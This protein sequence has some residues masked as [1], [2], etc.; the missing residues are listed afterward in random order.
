MR[1]QQFESPIETAKRLGTYNQVD[2]SAQYQN[3]RYSS[4]ML[5][6]NQNLLFAEQRRQE[7]TKFWH[8][9]AILVISIALTNAPAIYLWL[10]KLA[11]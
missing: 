11:Q 9:V 8:S 2:R 6:R 10:A 4:E 5:L 7:K 3:E 1:D